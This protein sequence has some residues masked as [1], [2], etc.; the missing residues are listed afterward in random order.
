MRKNGLMAKAAPC[1]HGHALLVQQRQHEVLV[2]VDLDALGRG[3]ADQPLAGRID[4]ERALR[5]R[6]LEAL[7][8]VQHRHHEIAPLHERL[9]VAR[10]EVLRTVQRLHAR[11]LRDRGRVGG[12]LR[13]QLAHRLD[14]QL[15]AGGIAEPPAGHAVGLGEAVQGQRA[16]VQAGLD[17]GRRV[18]LVVVV[19]Q[20]LVHVVGQHPDVRV[21]SAASA[22]RSAPSAPPCE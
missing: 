10:D 2:G 8:L 6:A 19:E 3:L 15:R 11:P 13:L 7:G 17:L 20:V 9:V 16:L 12:R 5:L 21:A 18:E 14:Q 22:R 1:T 4:V